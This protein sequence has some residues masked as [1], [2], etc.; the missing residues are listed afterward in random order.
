MLAAN[1]PRRYGSLRCRK[2]E[3]EEKAQKEA[4]SPRKLP[5]S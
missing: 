3:F 5:A 4:D 1:R 2:D